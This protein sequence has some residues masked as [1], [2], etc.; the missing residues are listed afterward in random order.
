LKRYLYDRWRGEGVRYVLLVGDADLMPVRY[1]VLDRVTEPAFDYAFYPSDLY[2]SDL[3]KQDGSFDDWNARREGFQAGYYGEV[4]GEKNKDDPINFDAI[5]YRPDVALGRWPVSTSDELAVVIQKSIAYERSILEAG[6]RNG[7]AR[8][9]FVAC[10][11]WIEN[12]GIMDA[13]AGHLE[14]AFLVEKRYFA[15]ESRDDGTPPPD[16]DTIISLINGGCR[17]V[18]HSGHGSD[19]DWHG[20]LGVRSLARLTNAQAPSILLSAGC[21]T[22]RFATLPPYEAYADIDGVEHGGTNGGQ[23]FDA[24]PPPPSP[25]QCGE[26]NPT[27]LGEQALRG[28][29]GG[30]VAYIGCNT[31]SQPCGMTLLDGFARAMAADAEARLGDCWAAALSH[32]YDAEGLATIEPTESWYPA[33]IF[34]QGMKFMLFGDPSLPLPQ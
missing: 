26:H 8:A 4:R 33:S 31:G 11:G 27:G 22:A 20:S 2:Y 7:P 14:G 32:Y 10:G 12:R 13:V 25:Y 29:A 6:D 5:D 9:A 21:S 1:M 16:E 23:V 19:N 3:A 15:D 24:P 30:A 28:A 17:L 34:F 18:F